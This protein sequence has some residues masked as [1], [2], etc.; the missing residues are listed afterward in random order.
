MSSCGAV[1]S[2]AIDRMKK[3]TELCFFLLILKTCYFM[4]CLL[5]LWVSDVATYKPNRS[6][7]WASA[8]FCLIVKATGTATVCTH[9]IS[10]HCKSESYSW[11]QSLLP[12]PAFWQDHRNP[13]QPSSHT[14][15]E[16]VF[17]WAPASCQN[18]QES[19]LRMQKRL[20]KAHC[21]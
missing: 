3:T 5:V 2:Q 7:T 1:F 12:L 21:S 6:M 20:N 11:D 9:T 14:Q 18:I 13:T 19:S 16:G 17:L 10:Y 15:S 4:K 8:E